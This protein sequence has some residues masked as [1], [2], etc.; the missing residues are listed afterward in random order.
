MTGADRKLEPPRRQWRKLNILEYERLRP[1]A[2][3]AYDFAEEKYQREHKA[4]LAGIREQ[5]KVRTP[6]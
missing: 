4:W 2:R 3:E 5:R 6:E 1:A